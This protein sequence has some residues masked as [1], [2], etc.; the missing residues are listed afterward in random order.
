MY[1]IHI[2]SGVQSI[3]QGAKDRFSWDMIGWLVFLANVNIKLESGFTSIEIPMRLVLQDCHEN[4]IV[5][6]GFFIPKTFPG[7]RV[8][9]R[10]RT[11]F[12]FNP[13]INKMDREQKFSYDLASTF[14]NLFL[15]T[16]KC[17]ECTFFSIFPCL[18][19]CFSFFN[20]YN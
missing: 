4:N 20:F 9:W 3:Q 12:R 18:I 17:N 19:P 8:S 13:E 14:N 11:S 7:C 6:T 15:G 5:L 16:E 2:R 10:P 1:L